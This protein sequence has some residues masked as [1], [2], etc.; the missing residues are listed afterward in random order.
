MPTLILLVKNVCLSAD[1]APLFLGVFNAVSRCVL[2]I[3]AL[4]N[5]P[6]GNNLSFTR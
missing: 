6:G 4:L 3:P 2:R 1:R 5:F